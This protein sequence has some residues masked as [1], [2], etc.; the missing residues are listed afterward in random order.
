MKTK[1]RKNGTQSS[2]SPSKII[3]KENLFMSKSE[4]LIYCR[5]YGSKWTAVMIIK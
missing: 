2:F 3:I 5:N 4:L 1:T